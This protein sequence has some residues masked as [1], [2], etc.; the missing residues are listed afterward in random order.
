[1]MTQ[2]TQQQLV[3]LQFILLLVALINGIVIAVWGVRR[4]RGHATFAPRWSLADVWFGI[5][6]ILALLIVTLLPYM[7]LLIGLKVDLDL[8]DLGN[9]VTILAFVLPSTYLQNAFFFGVPAAFI[10]LKYRLR[11]RDIGLP[12]LP[13]KQHVVAGLVLGVTVMLLSAGIEAAIK[14]V[15]THYQH[16]P[17][18]HALSETDKINPVADM[19]RALPHLGIVGF[20]LTVLAVGVSAP[21]GEEMLFRGFAFNALKKRFGLGVGIF[22]SALLFTLPHG[23]GFGL[24]PV[25]I[26][27]VVFAWVYHNSGSLWV[28]ILM[29][30]TNNTA[31][32]VLA[33][34]FPELAK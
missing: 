11:L 6:G 18:V 21:L 15:T 25:F 31:S 30:L 29:H 2:D 1:M 4:L 14:A 20:I 24:I 34:F 10:N 8:S 22:I 9:R 26:M 5:Q 28:P 17:W 32:V 23:Y 19:I 16:V 3:L 12:S 33:Y 7:L 13:P 27:G